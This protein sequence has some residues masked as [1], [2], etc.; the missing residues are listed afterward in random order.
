VLRAVGAT[1]AIGI[2]LLLVLRPIVLGDGF[3]GLDLLTTAAI[4]FGVGLFLR[5]QG[6]RTRTIGFPLL[7][8][9]LV[10]LAIGI[11]MVAF[12]VLWCCP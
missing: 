8:V 2:A 5:W 1:V 11:A 6:G 7:L 9:G 3:S 4:L 10:L 12:S